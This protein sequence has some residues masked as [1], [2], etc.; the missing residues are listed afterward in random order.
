DLTDFG[1]AILSGAA[2]QH[3]F[4]VRNDGGAKLTTSGL[5]LPAG[6]TLVE[7]LSASIS[8]GSSDTFTVQME[9]TSTGTRTGQIS[10]ADNDSDENPFVFSISGTVRLPPAPEITVLGNGVSIAAGDSTPSTT[11]QTNFGSAVLAGAT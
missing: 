8:P 11:D 7:G 2:V 1:G 9:T 4:T 5:S 6:F 10:F 3:T